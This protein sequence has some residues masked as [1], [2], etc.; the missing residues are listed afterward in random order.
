MRLRGTGI[1]ETNSPLGPYRVLDLTEGGYLIGGKILA[2]L[3]ADVI[4]IEPPGGSPSRDIGP[5]YKDIANR[6][7]S[8]FWFAY[9]VN[10]RS[11]TLDVG[12]EDGREVFLSLVANADIVLESFAPG[13]LEKLGLGYAVLSTVK[14]D[15]IVTSIT[16]FGQTGPHAS[17]SSCDLTA[18]ASG[19]MM[20]LSGDPDRAPV[21]PSVPQATLH[22]GAEAAAAS[23]IAL[24][25]RN[26]SGKGHHVDISTQQCVI[27]T[28]LN[29]TGKWDVNHFEPRRCSGAIILPRVNVRTIFPCKDGAVTLYI[30]GGAMASLVD[31]M[32]RFV[33]WMDE[34][35]MAPEWLRTLDWVHAYDMSSTSQEVIDRVEKPFADFF[36]TKTKAELYG[37]A[38]KRR[39]LLAPVNDVRDTVDD[40]QLQA[41]GFW[42]EVDHPELDD[43]LVYCGPFIKFSETPWQVRLRPPLIGEHNDEIYRGE[44]GFSKERIS[45][46]K[47]ARVI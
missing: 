8:L 4:K 41:R 5:F 10:K 3:G 43:S 26:V 45:L 31:N 21:A 13:Y 23:V 40:V 18:W 38:L 46:L 42:I 9:N 35:G 6:E 11:I 14:P 30:A 28:T 22:G 25:H 20:C 16:P 12:K 33:D 2:D 7:K 17:Y 39:L 19:G 1:P 47:Q 24:W 34:E 44:L 32:K 36:L 15:I 37:E 27:W 29:A